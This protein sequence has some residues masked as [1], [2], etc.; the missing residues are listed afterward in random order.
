MAARRAPFFTMK[1]RPFFG[2]PTP[3]GELRAGVAYRTRIC[4]A[5]TRSSSMCIRDDDSPWTANTLQPEG[6]LPTDEVAGRLVS[7]GHATRYVPEMVRSKRSK[8]FRNDVETETFRNVP[9]R[10]ISNPFR[11]ISFV[12]PPGAFVSYMVMDTSG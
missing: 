2:I 3:T 5:R 9:K 10:N 12:P 4:A 6:I 1:A 8:T 7:R 11:S